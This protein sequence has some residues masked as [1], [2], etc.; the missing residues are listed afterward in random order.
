MG[1]V[2]AGEA[3]TMMSGGATTEEFTREV[4]QLRRRVSEL[5]A[6]EGE[7][8]AERDRT[9]RYLD[10]AGVMFV[11]IG[12]DETVLLVNQKGCEL[13][14][15]AEQEVVGRNWFETFLPE[16]VR[17]DTREVFAKL[18]AGELGV[19]EYNENPVLNKDG[20]ERVIAWHNT[21]LA[22]QTGD[23]IGVISSGEDITERRQAEHALVESKNRYHNLFQHSRD[24]I[25]IA[26]REGRFVDVNQSFL[27]LFG[28]SRERIAALTMADLYAEPGEPR[29]F[30]QEIEQKG[31]VVDREVKM[32]RLDGEVIDCLE[33]AIV[34]HSSDGAIA[35]YEG[36]IRDVTERRRAEAEL[37]DSEERFRVLFEYAPDAYFL[38]D[39]QGTF[40]DANRV[41]EQ[42]L[43]CRRQELVGKS[44]FQTRL[45][46]ARELPR[47]AA[48]LARSAL[49]QA[50]GPDE[51]EL[52]I[53]NGT[54]T[55][56]EISTFPVKLKGASVVL[57]IARDV[58]SRKQAEDALR[59]SERRY[60]ELFEESPIALSEED[61]SEIKRYIDEL[62]ASGVK[63]CRAYFEAHPEVVRQAAALMK[64]VDVNQANLDLYGARSKQELL[65]GLSQLLDE[66]S[67]DVFREELVAIAEGKSRFE[68][69]TKGRTLQGETKDIV[70]RWTVASGCE[71]T[72]SSLLVSDVDVTERRCAERALR[73]SE[74]RYRDLFES[75]HDLVQSVGPDGRLRYVNPA[76]RETLGYTESEV[77]KLSVFDILHPDSKEHCIDIFGR[78]MSGEDVGSIEAEFVTKDG[79]AIAVEGDANCKFLDGKPVSTQGIFRD[80][81]DRKRAEAQIAH[82]QSLMLALSKAAAAVQRARTPSEVYRTVGDEVAKLGYHTTILTLTDDGSQL[83]ISHLTFESRALRAA[84]KLTG[85]SSARVRFE[86][87]PGS[88]YDQA[89]KQGKARFAEQPGELISEALPK[90]GRRLAKQVAGLLGLAESISAPLTVGG[91]AVGVLYIMGDGLTEDDIPAVTAFANQ[92]AIALQNARLYHALAEQELQLR[93]QIE[94]AP[95][96]ILGLDLEENITLF[97]REAER[98]LGHQQSDMLGRPFSQLVCPEYLE[99]VGQLLSSETDSGVLQQAHELEIFDR[100][101]DRVPLEVRV[102]PLEKRGRLTGWQV[103]GRDISERKHLEEMKSQFI[104]TVSHD[105]RTP[106]ASIMGFSET[107]M[108]GSPGPLTEVQ[109]EFLGIIFE[110]SQRQLALVN[111]LLDV[112]KLEA[113]RLQLE[114]ETVHLPELIWGVVEGMRPLAD[115]KGVVLKMDVNDGLPSMEGDPQR[116]E[117]VVNNLLSN[118][119]K[120]T[121]EGGSVEVAAWQDDGHLK[122]RVSDTGVGIPPEDLPNLFQPFHR[123]RNVTKKAIEGTGLGLTIVKALVEAHKGTVEV[124]S[125][126][127]K[128]TTF[129]V[130]L[131][132]G[133]PSLAETDK[134]SCEGVGRAR[135]AV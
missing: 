2:F 105:L 3:R 54:K 12:A 19:A 25:C 121:P 6:L 76:W 27:D 49:G 127:N 91:E 37:R 10:V 62:R 65:R 58:S 97:N 85:L 133:E 86:I 64:T 122:I 40:V 130:T 42:L 67:Y 100:W 98:L 87:R 96:A 48:I 113:G 83:E 119:V 16:R 59:A 94:E 81:T 107:L 32:R 68:A 118:A 7:L 108:E 128:G 123:G 4:L 26:T 79:R 134:N 92:T 11:V 124:E 9:Q 52:N 46:P 41:T 77:E 35:G 18:M 74:E 44:L 125:E 78:V 8:R 131:P 75:A 102:S 115:K 135:G 132:L 61:A 89:V 73:E 82:A 101:G 50:T 20:Q 56:V 36:I 39:L 17:T 30:Q 106:L 126:L 114:M 53:E 38:S 95:D 15:C 43:G 24:A 13:L 80:V 109:K 111:D 66:D 69:E 88:V 71:K 84:E 104:A 45:L 34:R 55:I 112:S 93:D 72:Y 57:G 110:S 31:S 23:I 21:V 47:V 117:R 99:L 60:R 51:F 22:D 103:I 63:D 29:R 14:G 120:F 1:A 33:T 116:L 28:I 70:L 129:R 90:L 5:E